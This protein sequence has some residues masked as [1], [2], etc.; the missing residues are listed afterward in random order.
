MQNSF[1]IWNIS[2]KFSKVKMK[3]SFVCL[4][5]WSFVT[6][7]AS[8]T[9]ASIVFLYVPAGHLVEYL[10]PAKHRIDPHDEGEFYYFY[11]IIYFHFNNYIDFT[12]T[13]TKNIDENVWN[14]FEKHVENVPL[15]IIRPSTIRAAAYVP[16][17]EWVDSVSAVRSEI[18]M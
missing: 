15:V 7:I 4:E 9:S 10:F 5:I 14:N 6:A 2:L 12:Y 16:I 11:Y 17:F 13:F 1:P 18:Q 8:R 3:F